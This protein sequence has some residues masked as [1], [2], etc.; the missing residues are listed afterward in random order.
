MN[1]EQQ[2]EALAFLGRAETYGPG[3]AAVERIDTHISAVFLA[4]DRAYKLKRAVAF[5]YLDFSTLARREAACQAEVRLNRR[6]APDLYLGVWRITREPD[7]S[8]AFNGAGEVIDAVVVMNRFDQ[9]LL[10]DR[11]AE[12][13]ALDAATMEELSLEIARFHA[14]AEPTP[15]RGGRASLE[16]EIDGNEQNFA[17]APKGTLSPA[18]C[19]SL[20]TRWRALLARDAALLDQRDREAK[21][22]RCHGDL[23]LRN[24]CLWR[25]RPT[26]FDC[27]EFSEHLSCID[28]LYDLAF[29]LM[30]LEH[31]DLGAF[32]NLVFNAYLDANDESDGVAALRLMMSLRAG[33]R[34]HIGLAAAHAQTHPERVQ[35][36]VEESS[37]YL[38]L[39]DRLLD[40][41]PPQLLAIGGLSGTGK[42]TLARALA[43]VAAGVPG[44]RLLH[45]DALRKALF[46][47]AK[48]ERLPETAYVPEVSER[49]Y[50]CQRDQAAAYLRAGYSVIADGVFGLPQERAAIAA[51]AAGCGAPFHGL[52]LEAP[53]D[54]LRRRIGERRVDMSDATADVLALQLDYDVGAI[55]WP[56]INA[57]GE[58]AA[59]IASARARL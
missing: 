49:V 10:F 32:A 13:G 52:W 9:A 54:A 33:I 26:L 31:R 34:A 46:H 36:I 56:R 1:A 21:A 18:L 35:A 2:A 45:T 37:A 4:G 14:A 44:A 57:G 43:P 59:V 17:R 28:V 27:I 22:R 41:G 51:V 23:H 7:G 29:L 3:A 39:A 55:D 42:S 48:T 19:R 25:G 8:C 38:A 12:R 53:V 6:T 50:R 58:P 16:I 24:I 40:A 11:L 47:V 15:G 5:S 20:V 30:D